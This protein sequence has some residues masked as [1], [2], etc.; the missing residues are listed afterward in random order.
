VCEPP[1]DVATLQGYA[2]AGVD[3]ALMRVTPDNAD[4]ALDELDR[5]ARLAQHLS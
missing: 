2:D 1:Y 3:R 5:I 4:L